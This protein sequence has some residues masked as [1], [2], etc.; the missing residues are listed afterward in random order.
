MG[1]LKLLDIYEKEVIHASHVKEAQHNARF[2]FAIWLE[3]HAA[4]H[5]LHPTSESLRYLQ[6]TLTP[7]QLSALKDLLNPLTCG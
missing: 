2:D 4:E 1:Y 7:R 6:E 3:N 5:G